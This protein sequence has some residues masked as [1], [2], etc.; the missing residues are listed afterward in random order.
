MTNIKSWLSCIGWSVIL[1]YLVL[2]IPMFVIGTF[3]RNIVWSDPVELWRDTAAKSPNKPRPRINIGYEL[4]K[5]DQFSAAMI[6]YETAYSLSFNPALEP[7]RAVMTRQLAL[8]NISEIQ[9]R[10]GKQEAAYQSLVL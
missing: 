5:R 1:C 9:L 4:H 3:Q 6:E 2:L 8:T 7:G 10:F